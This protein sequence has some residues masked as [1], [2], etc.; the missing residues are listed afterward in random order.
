[1]TKNLRIYESIVDRVEEERASERWI[2]PW[3]LPFIKFRE[4][5]WL[6]PLKKKAPLRV[7]LTINVEESPDTQAFLKRA[8][9][10]AQTLEVPITFFFEENL[11]FRRLLY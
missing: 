4:R 3:A 5:E 10:F 9:E 11:L 6:K 1:M 7:C 8:F 2:M